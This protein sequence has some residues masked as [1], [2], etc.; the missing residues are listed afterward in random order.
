[1][2]KTLMMIAIAAL[3]AGPA[4]AQEEGATDAKRG[5]G[6]AE[7]CDVGGMRGDRMA[8]RGGPGGDGK[9]MNAEMREQMKATHE[10]IRDLAGAIRL[11]TDEAQK[12]ELTA[13]LRAKLGE[14]ADRMQTVQTERLAQAEERLAALKQKIEE[15]QANRDA[16]IEE[17]LQRVL[18][19]ER[20]PHGDRFKDFPQAKGGRKGGHGDWEGGPGGD[21]PPPPAEDMPDDMPP[22]PE[23]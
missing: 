13:Q 12:A 6:P 20:P 5:G 4:L 9:T 14:V 21:L 19:G 16:R 22:P 18:S 1:M 3:A 23:E 15:G 8:K 2:K 17:Q 10:A 11:E 7:G